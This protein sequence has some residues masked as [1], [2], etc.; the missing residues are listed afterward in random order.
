MK[1]DT[2][3][4]ILMRASTFLVVSLLLLILTFVTI[5]GIGKFD[6]HFFTGE[7]DDKTSYVYVETDDTLG[8]ETKLMEVEDKAYPTIT[9]INTDSAVKQG[10]MNSELYPLKKGDVILKVDSTSTEDIADVE[11]IPLESDNVRLKVLR[12]GE[13]IFPLMVNT[14]LVIVFSLLISLPI[15]IMSAIYLSEYAKPSRLLSIIRFSIS[16]LA[17]VP[18]IIYGLFGMLLFV[19]VMRFGYSILAGSFTLSIVLLPTLITQA[20]ESLKRVPNTLREGSLALGA[21]KLRT[22]SKVVLPNSISGIVV[23]ILLSIGRIIGESAALLLTA[24]TVGAI[25]ESV[26]QSGSTLTVKAY[27]VVKESGDIALG[28]A[29]GLVTIL[30]VIIINMLVKFTERFDKMKESV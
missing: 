26:F 13:G 17:G 7:F 27:T 19:T 28:C 9:K 2:I 8:I 22:I 16:C 5:Q 23:G 12:P 29:M 30:M 11:T 15:S 6:L 14:L 20:E 10:I 21:S 3:F 4:N 25:P 24:G 18:S 1:K